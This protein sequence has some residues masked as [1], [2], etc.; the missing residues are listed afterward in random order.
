MQP[1]RRTHRRPRRAGVT[2]TELL[3]AVSIV[4]ILAGL[5]FTAFSV[6]QHAVDKL[7]GD[8]AK[9]SPQHAKKKRPNHTPR[10][11]KWVANQYLV[12]FRKSVA[13]PQAE[14]NR[15]A[16]TLPASLVAVYTTAVK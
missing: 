3:V 5:T 15:L 2:L 12:T 6:A 9:A 16:Q 11:A 7:E 10:L 14:A 8:V 1:L 4:G 13:D